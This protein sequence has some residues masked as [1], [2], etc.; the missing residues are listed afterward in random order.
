MYY[1]SRLSAEIGA[2][3]FENTSKSTFIYPHFQFFLVQKGSVSIFF[4]KSKTEYILHENDVILVEPDEEAEI[5][6]ITGLSNVILGVRVDESFMHS[7]LPY[8]YHFECNSALRPHKDYQQL[9][10]ILSLLASSFFIGDS[11]YIIYAYLY[12]LA[13]CLGA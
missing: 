7:I 5:R 10:R 12:Q 13:D 1:I 9:N 6:P 11:E 2:R 8:Q 3:I 4:S